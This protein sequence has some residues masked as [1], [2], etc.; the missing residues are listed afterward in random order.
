MTAAPD[1]KAVFFD[2]DGT[3]VSFK[4]H[5]VTQSNIEV[6]DALRR[7]GVKVFISTGRMLKMTSV[8]NGIEFD[9]YMIQPRR[10][11][12][13]ALSLRRSYTLFA[14]GFSGLTY[15]RLLDLLWRPTTIT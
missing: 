1:I 10:C 7:K 14:K 4:T 6:L 5:K 15:L 2:I 13:A 9:G 8:L 12:S 11:Y 3:L